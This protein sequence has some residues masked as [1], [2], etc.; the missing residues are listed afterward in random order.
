[1]QNEETVT[2]RSEQIDPIAR[3][4]LVSD[5]GG[6]LADLTA[7]RDRLANEKAEI[8]DQLL[9]RTAEF[10]NFRRR[11]ERERI[12]LSDYASMEAV[13][14][15][16]PVLDDFERALKIETADKEYAKGMELIYQ[17]MVEQLRKLGLEPL[18]TS[19][20]K[21]DPNLHHAI[22]MADTKDAEDQAILAEF[23]SGYKFRGRLLRPALV[24]VAVNQ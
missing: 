19:G 18:S 9:R 7:E 11:T 23:Q 4:E 14:A 6:D 22:E 5:A 24:K 15:M 8:Y 21:F 1:M 10:D 2:E 13:K 20:Q 17:R 3:P 12:D 16:L